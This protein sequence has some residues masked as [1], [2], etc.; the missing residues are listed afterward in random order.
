MF[1]D[2]YGNALTTTSDAA[3]DAYVEGVDRFLASDGGVEPAFEK[4]IAADDGFALAHLGLARHLQASGNSIEAKRALES[5]RNLVS[6]V[7]SREAS[8]INALGLLIEGKTAPA[9]NAI[10]AHLVEY[11]RDAMVAQTCTTVF[12][13]IGFSGLRGRE[14]EQLAFTTVLA[15]H[16]GDDWWFLSQHAF[17]QVEVGQ[18][19]PAE[20]NIERSLEIHPRSAQGAHIRSHIYYESGEAEAGYEYLSE[21]RRDYD[22]TG[23][24]HGHLSWHEA[25]WALEHGRVEE[26]WQIVDGDIAPGAAC[27]PPLVM[28]CDISAVLYRAALLGIAVPPERWESVVKFAG[29]HFPNTGI[30]F[31]D[32]HAAIAYAMAGDSSQLARIVSD[33]KGPAA[34]VVRTLAEAFGAIAGEDWTRATSLLT[35][36]MADHAR[37]GVAKHSAT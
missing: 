14:A 19:T 11:P 37:I 17:S 22:R 3:R 35:A 13:L 25:L 6:G 23:M 20:N 31:G 12:G 7:T 36:I 2:R 9:Y 34:E 32:V 5:V 21:W 15:P 33:A 29:K 1:K 24:L 28:L 30:A 27:G 16:Y 10:R 26:M 18:I 4:C 8:Q